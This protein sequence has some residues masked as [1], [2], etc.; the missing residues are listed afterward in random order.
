MS[1]RYVDGGNAKLARDQSAEARES[2]TK[3]N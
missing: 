2:G 3:L 1:A